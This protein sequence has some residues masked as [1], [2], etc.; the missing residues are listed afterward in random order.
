MAIA[1]MPGDPQQACPIGALDFKD[2]LGGRMHM[3]IATAV[4][5]QPITLRQMPGLR[6]VEEKGRT[7]IA[8]EADAA[9]VAVEIS[10][11]DRID[12]AVLRPLTAGMDGNGST[13]PCAQYKK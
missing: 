10:E 3:D 9:A 4:E 11:G 13:H 2:W 6:Q 12:R 5:L 1:E 8:D 7:R